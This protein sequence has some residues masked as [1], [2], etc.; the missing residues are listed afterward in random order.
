LPGAPGAPGAPGEGL[1]KDLTQLVALTWTH[2]QGGNS[3]LPVTLL[4]TKKTFLGIAVRFSAAVRML[5]HGSEFLTPHAF[6]VR[7]PASSLPHVDSPDQRVARLSELGPTLC[8]CEAVG[9]V[10]PAKLNAG[11]II[12]I[13]GPDS[14]VFAFVFS[15]PAA[16]LARKSGRAWVQ[17]RGDFFIDKNKRAADVEYARAE[18]PTGDRPQASK[19]GIQG[20]LFESWFWL[21]DIKFQS[22]SG[23]IDVNRADRE[24]LIA[25]RGIGDARAARIVELRAQQPFSDVDEFAQRVGL[26][27]AELATLRA[28]IT[29]T[30]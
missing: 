29:V 11:A 10:V 4:G 30:P 20:G 9:V 19:F 6:T 22:V 7:L 13:P 21:G 16:D 24:A 12:E 2:D 15:S 3:L 23:Q 5:D 18:L 17:I 1:E 14:E 28:F 26:S 8:H 27:A 25:L